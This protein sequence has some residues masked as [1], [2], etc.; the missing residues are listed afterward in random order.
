MQTECLCRMYSFLRCRF[1]L[2]SSDNFQLFCLNTVLT[3]KSTNHHASAFAF[4]TKRFAHSQTILLLSDLFLPYLSLPFAAEPFLSCF[5]ASSPLNHNSS[6]R[7]FRTHPLS[8]TARYH[9][10][11]TT[12]RRISKKPTYSSD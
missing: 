4:Y 7:N 8:E 1:I 6:R 9:S 2:T 10:E 11:S 5:G 12:A 3:A